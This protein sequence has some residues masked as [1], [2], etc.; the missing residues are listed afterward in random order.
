MDSTTMAENLREIL[1]PGDTLLAIC[2]NVSRN[3][4]NRSVRCLASRDGE[5]LDV[6]HMVAEVLNLRCD[7]SGGVR[8]R[9]CGMDMGF[10]LTYT[11]SAKL[12]GYENRGGYAIR[13]RRG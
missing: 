7:K 6:S 4:M 10:W 11:L 5:P 1:K 2:Y 8:V 3:G 9:G 12:Y 13:H